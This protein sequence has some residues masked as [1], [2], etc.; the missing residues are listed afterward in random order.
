MRNNGANG[1]ARFANLTNGAQES[2]HVVSSLALRW[3]VR[4]PIERDAEKASRMRPTSARTR[5]GL[6]DRFELFVDHYEHTE[7][8]AYRLP[9]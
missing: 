9:K 4:R 5:I 6:R 1:R 3:S 2:L 7:R 8:G